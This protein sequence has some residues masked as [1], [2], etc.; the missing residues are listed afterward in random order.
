MR[1][2][3]LMINAHAYC[4]ILSRIFSQLKFQVCCSRKSVAKASSQVSFI[5][6]VADVFGAVNKTYD[7]VISR[8]F[9]S[10][11]MGV[12]VPITTYAL[13]GSICYRTARLPGISEK[14]WPKGVTG[15]HG[16]K[17][18]CHFVY[19]CSCAVWQPQYS[20]HPMVHSWP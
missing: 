20:L 7:E 12:V 8:K 6:T 16:M 4:W 19:V 9:E 11:Q 13:P 3:Q 1:F 18:P 10:H 14:I 17:L 5:N 15:H 2:G